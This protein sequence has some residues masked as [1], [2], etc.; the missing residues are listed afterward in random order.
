M[1]VRDFLRQH[2]TMSL[3]T[4]SAEG[5]PQSA[6][7][8]YAADEDMNLY[9][10]S[11]PKSRHCVNLR[12]NPRVAATIQADG[13]AWRAIQGLQ[14]EGTVDDL[15]GIGQTAPAAKVYVA[16]FDFLKGLLDARGGESKAGK[17][18]QGTSLGRALA[19]SK[20]YVLRPTWIRMID[21]TLGFGHKDE[22]RLDPM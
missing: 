1:R 21:N 20:F 12:R 14:I 19:D 7:L 22:I 4:V 9:F 18:D 3:A 2:T 15:A 5:N 11:S 16:R 17:T 10:L 13:Q 6:A 8:Y